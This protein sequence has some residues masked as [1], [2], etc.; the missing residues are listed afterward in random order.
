MGT[1]SFSYQGFWGE[2]I[3]KYITF[4]TNSKIES[5]YDQEIPQS[6][7]ADKPMEPRGR[8]TKQ[9]TRHQ[10]DKP[11]NATSYLLP[12]KMIAN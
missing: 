10:Q 12:V 7:A 6:L 11:S 5:E 2:R 3:D 8:A 1:F 9:I 4:V